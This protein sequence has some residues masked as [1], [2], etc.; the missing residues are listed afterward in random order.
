MYFPTSNETLSDFFDRFEQGPSPSTTH[1]ASM[2]D[3][4]ADVAMWG[5][6]GGAG[7]FLVVL[8]AAV[9]VLQKYWGLAERIVQSVTRL[10]NAITALVNA[11]REPTPSA[12]EPHRPTPRNLSDD[13]IVMREQA[14]RIA[15][16]AQG[17]HL[18]TVAN[19]GAYVNQSW[20]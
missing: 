9:A 8:A 10:L 17:R 16:L 19:E 20:I 1:D 13:E 6:V 18:Y 3:E 2:A 15:R 11:P 14:E 12:P 4:G 7:G 5:S